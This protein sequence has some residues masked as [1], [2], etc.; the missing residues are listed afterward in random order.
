[1]DRDSLVGISSKRQQEICCVYCSEKGQTATQ[2]GRAKG[3]WKTAYSFVGRVEKLSGKFDHVSGYASL[4]FGLADHFHRLEQIGTYSESGADKT[5]DALCVAESVL[6]K[7][8]IST[9]LFLTDTLSSALNSTLGR[10]TV[11]AKVRIFARTAD[12]R[13][14]K[15]SD[16]TLSD[17]NIR[18]LITMAV[19]Y[20]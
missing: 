3:S 8:A 4:V 10:S 18:R 6:A 11:P 7:M 2:H 15:V 1:M 16:E 20:I 14:N 12:L 13:L 19:N 17:T 5:V 9:P